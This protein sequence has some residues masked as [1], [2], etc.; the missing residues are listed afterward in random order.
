MRS[1]AERVARLVALAALV[2]SAVSL[3]RRVVVDTSLRG[4]ETHWTAASVRLAFDSAPAPVD[5]DWLAAIRRSGVAVTWSWR[6][7]PPAPLAIAAAPLA[8]PAGATRVTVAAPSGTRVTLS[9]RLGPID[10]AN[11]QSGGLTAVV[12][13]ALRTIAASG[14]RTTVADSLALRP[15][16]VLGTV[17]WETKFVVRSLEERGWIVDTRLV[18]GPGHTVSQRVLPPVD[19]AHYAAVLALDS[20]ARSASASLE[21]YAKQGGGVIVAGSAGRVLGAIAPAHLDTWRDARPLS[22]FRLVGADSLV[23]RAGNV[24]QVGY[25]DTWRLRMDSAR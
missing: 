3:V 8:D 17:G 20:G 19:T 16:L 9:D 13:V 4:A 11:A 25:D 10:T 7:R 22:Y 12:P 1:V 15:L 14:A 6:R 18:I 5:R 23:A 2:L 21:R 24:I